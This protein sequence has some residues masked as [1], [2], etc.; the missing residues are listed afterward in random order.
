[1]FGER[2]SSDVYSAGPE[3]MP[4]ASSRPGG[5][6]RGMARGCDG[7]ARRAERAHGGR[8]RPT[9]IQGAE[10]NWCQHCPRRA[11]SSFPPHCSRERILTLDPVMSNFCCLPGRAVRSGN[12]VRLPTRSGAGTLKRIGNSAASCASAVGSWS[13]STYWRN[14]RQ[15]RR[16]TRPSWSRT[17][18]PFTGSRNPRDGSKCEKLTLSICF[19]LYPQCDF[20]WSPELTPGT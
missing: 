2:I 16:R 19:P 4:P 7:R 1:M 20:G 9:R 13:S 5:R 3:P 17:P 8:G 18:Q 12:V 14:G 11:R 15:T 10:I 6:R